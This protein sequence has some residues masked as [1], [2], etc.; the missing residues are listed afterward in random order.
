MAEL[1]PRKKRIA[2]KQFSLQPSLTQE[3]LRYIWLMPSRLPPA[4]SASRLQASFPVLLRPH[5]CT[6]WVS[7]MLILTHAASGN[8]SVRMSAGGSNGTTGVGQT[9]TL[10]PK[11]WSNIAVSSEGNRPHSHHASTNASHARFCHRL[12]RPLKIGGN[13]GGCRSSPRSEEVLLRIPPQFECGSAEQH[14]RG[15]PPGLS[16]ASRVGWGGREEKG[17]PRSKKATHRVEAAGQGRGLMGEL[18]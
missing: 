15:R 3:F 14:R 6:Y 4:R 8:L 2:S 7:H 18:A 13:T 11:K 16:R 5:T 1:L 17:S 12:S 9:R 10:P